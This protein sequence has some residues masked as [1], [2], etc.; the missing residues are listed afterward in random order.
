LILL[1]E[2]AFLV[3]QWG[4]FAKNEGKIPVAHPAR[5]WQSVIAPYEDRAT[6]RRPERGRCRMGRKL[7]GRAALF[8]ARPFLFQR[9]I[10]SPDPTPQN[11]GELPHSRDSGYSP[12][13][14]AKRANQSPVSFPVLMAKTRFRGFNA[15]VSA[16]T[17]KPKIKTFKPKLECST[18]EYYLTETLSRHQGER[19]IKNEDIHDVLCRIIRERDDAMKKLALIVMQPNFQIGFEFSFFQS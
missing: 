14:R 3:G 5:S 18:L 11:G 15:S 6:W 8:A 7:P 12:F 2:N 19:G 9:S 10:P 1:G 4:V 16:K 13:P 17:K